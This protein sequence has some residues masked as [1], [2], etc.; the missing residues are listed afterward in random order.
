MPGIQTT[1]INKNS[2]AVEIHGAKTEK[3]K[4]NLQDQVDAASA[5]LHPSPSDK[6]PEPK[7][8]IES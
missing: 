3:E 7:E 8:T 4:L 6:A 1:I 5:S 2:G